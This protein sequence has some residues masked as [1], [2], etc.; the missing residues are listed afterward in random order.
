MTRRI[1]N[2][3]GHKAN[4]DDRGTRDRARPHAGTRT[5]PELVRLMLADRNTIERF[6]KGDHE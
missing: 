4:S 1:P 5:D 2:I 3:Y 6:R